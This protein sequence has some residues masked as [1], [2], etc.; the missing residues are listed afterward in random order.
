MGLLGRAGVGGRRRLTRRA[1][2]P[3]PPAPRCETGSLGAGRVA[4]GGRGT[5]RPDRPRG[6]RRLLHRLDRS[7]PRPTPVVVRPGSTDECA[8]VVATCAEHGIAL[9][10]QGANTGWW[11]VGSP[12]T[13]RWCSACADWAPGG[14]PRGRPGHRGGRGDP[15]DARRRRRPAPGGPTGW[16]WPAGTRPPWAAWWPPTPGASTSCATAT[17]G[18]SWS[19]SKRCSGPARWCRT[20]GA[21]SRTTPATTLPGSSV[22]ARAPW[23]W[24]PRPVCGWW[25]PP[26]SGWWPWWPST[27]SAR[28]W[29]PPL[30]CGGASRRWPRPS[31]SSTTDW[32]WSVG[33]PGSAGPSP[34]AHRAYL[35]VEAAAVGR[36]LGRV[37]RCRRRLG[38]GGRRGGGRGLGPA[39]RALALP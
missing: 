2:P 32:P 10:L 38:V 21:W 36:P 28:R 33:S 20:S 29:P 5:P 37:G 34:T 1:G 15:G 6:G 18:P 12:C 17:P 4:R 31:S 7:L 11:A 26:L 16:T 3:G 25:P 23:A 39:G 9:S 19:G 8:A 13:V 22:G 14:R 35:L 30:T 27:T 24:S